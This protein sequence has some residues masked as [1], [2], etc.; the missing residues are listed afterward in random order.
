MFDQ[1][2]IQQ[3]SRDRKDELDRVWEQRRSRR[4]AVTFV[5]P[6]ALA[7]FLQRLIPRRAQR[8][9]QPQPRLDPRPSFE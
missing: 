8:R 4:Q 5:E 7:R 1:I 3:M 2:L 6:G 9:P